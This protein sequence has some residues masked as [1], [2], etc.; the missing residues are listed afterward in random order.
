MP[1]QINFGKHSGKTLEQ[2]PEAYISWMVRDEVYANRPDLKAALIA[3][4]FLDPS[5]VE[6]S[7]KVASSIRTC[8]RRI[9]DAY[10]NYEGYF[11]DDFSGQPLWRS[12][13]DARTYFNAE[14]SAMET[15]GLLPLDAIDLEMT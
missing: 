2:V 10:S 8:G 13:A 14:S 7:A 1:W 12:N 15:A 5:L 6:Q 11:Q 3:S 9:P 4:G